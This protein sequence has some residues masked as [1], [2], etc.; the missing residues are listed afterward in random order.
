MNVLVLSPCSKDKRYDPVLDCEGV[1][2][3][4]REKLLQAH[5]ESA[6][7]AAEMYTGNEHQ[8]IKTAVD[9]LRSSVDVDWYIISAGFG[10]LHNETEIPSY[11]CGFSDIESVRTRAERAGYDIDNLT[12]DE[13]IQMVGREKDI[14]QEFRKV[15]G[16]EY[17]LLFVV[18]SEP[19]LLSVTDALTRIPEQTVAFALASRGS[20]QFIG[21]CIWI[22]ATETERRALETTWM[23]IRGKR[24]LEIVKQV[25][26]DDLE[27]MRYDG[28][29]QDFP[30]P[31]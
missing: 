13:T 5:T 6:T 2:E 8:H 3:H 27:Q 11:E 31:D 1:D 4:S 28:S 26:E 23:E 15:L 16:Q 25:S 9:H 21:D 7:T 30:R 19:Y 24:F 10:L 14:P 17:D 22:P 18:L 29:S 20:K 12:N